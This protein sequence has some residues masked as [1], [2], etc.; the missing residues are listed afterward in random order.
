M[1]FFG[2]FPLRTEPRTVVRSTSV[3]SCFEPLVGSCSCFMK[4]KS[5]AKNR[6][7]ILERLSKAIS[8]EILAYSCCR[9]LKSFLTP[10]IAP[11]SR[12]IDAFPSLFHSGRIK[13][14]RRMLCLSFHEWRCIYLGQQ[15]ILAPFLERSSLDRAP[16]W[17]ADYLF[18]PKDPKADVL[19]TTILGPLR[20]GFPNLLTIRFNF[21]F[22]S[23]LSLSRIW[24]GFF[25]RR[26]SG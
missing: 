4:Q 9:E 20:C 12:A 16:G 5:C 8:Y 24:G 22:W 15:R 14:M 19:L 26:C 13:F 6:W 11:A 1:G 25:G 23:D 17:F 7:P 21:S 10:H 18:V 2:V 3:F